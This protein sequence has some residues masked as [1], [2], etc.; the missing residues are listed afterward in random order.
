M[1]IKDLALDQLLRAEHGN[2][3]SIIALGYCL[4]EVA[5]AIRSLKPSTK[6]KLCAEE[7]GKACTI[8]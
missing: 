4:L 7:E 1:T 5:D 2:S 6:T 3:D 8:I